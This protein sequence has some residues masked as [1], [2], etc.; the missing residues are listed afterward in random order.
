M[1]WF[2]TAGMGFV[3]IA[4]IV[5]L[6]SQMFV[7][8][9][10]RKYSQVYTLENITGADVARH[11]LRSKGITDVDVVTSNGGMLS[12]HYDPTKKIVA[13]SPK[14][15][16]ESSI[17]SV[18]VAAHECGHAVQ[19][20]EGYAFIG[21]RNRILPFAIIAGKFS[22]FPI[23]IGLIGGFEKFFSIGIIMLSIVALF[24]LVTL[25]VEFDA[26]IRAIKIL[27][28]DQILD[29]SELSGAKTML[30]AAA[31]TYVAA[32]LSS[33]MTILRYIAIFNSNQNRRK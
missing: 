22:M 8:S 10:Y 20:S 4:M 24:Q 19:H 17:A 32:L 16:N 23:I 6:I 29:A 25:P 7:Q 31:L 21:I 27:D 18:A 30:K 9:S 3:I 2:N 13:L 12:D 15:Y 1:F 5:S 26:S 11:I 33:I 28:T 14:V